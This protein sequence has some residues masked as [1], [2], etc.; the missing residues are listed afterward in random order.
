MSKWTTLSSKLTIY[1][2]YSMGLCLSSPELWGAHHPII[3]KVF[4]FFFTLIISSHWGGPRTSCGLI[5]SY[6]P[7]SIVQLTPLVFVMYPTSSFIPFLP[8]L[9]S[10]LS[11]LPQKK[12]L[13][14]LSLSCSPSLFVIS[15]RMFIMEDV[16]HTPT[17][18]SHEL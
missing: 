3:Y 14:S 1:I 17:V 15:K 2:F 13:L 10:T 7:L 6:L 5:L 16:P 9:Y 12:L 8:Q 11:L 18:E 4:F